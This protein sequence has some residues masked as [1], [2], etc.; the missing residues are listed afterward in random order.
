MAAV[1]DGVLGATVRDE[2]ADVAGFAA[3]EFAAERAVWIA[4]E[5][6]VLRPVGIFDAPVRHEIP[7]VGKRLAAVNAVERP[8]LASF[9]Q[10]VF[11]V[12]RGI[13]RATVAQKVPGIRK[14]LPA[15]FAVFAHGCWFLVIGAVSLR[16]MAIPIP[17]CPLFRL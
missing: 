13:L 7:Q 14:L 17:H 8:V 10:D 12:R 4:F 11:P 5:G 15:Q 6:F 3:A 9:E 1:A 16:K 2:T